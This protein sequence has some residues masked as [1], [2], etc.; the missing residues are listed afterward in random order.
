MRIRKKINYL[1]RKHKTNCPFEL[2]S[3]LNVHIRYVDLP[4]GVKGYCLRVLRRKFILLDYN[5]KGTQEEKFICTHELGHIVLHKEIS[6][7]FIIRHTFFVANKY[8]REAHHFAIYLILSNYEFE[9]G[10]TLSS[11]FQK[12]G[13][14]EKMKI[15]Y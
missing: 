14:P 6:H 4:E 5:L 12:N 13:I 3:L 10:E 7:Y 1:Y 2:A 15:Y 8:E 9:N 11:V